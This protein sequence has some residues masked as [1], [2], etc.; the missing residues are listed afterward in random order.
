MPRTTDRKPPIPAAA[1]PTYDAIVGL[2]DA[3]YQQHL[4]TEYEAV[5]RKMA[6]VP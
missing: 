5:C 3:F 1:K 6:G 4:N 2:P